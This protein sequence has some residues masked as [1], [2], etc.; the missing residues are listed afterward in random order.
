MD[1]TFC[2]VALRQRRNSPSAAVTKAALPPTTP[3]ITAPKSEKNSRPVFPN[4]GF[5]EHSLCS[6]D[7]SG[8]NKRFEI[9]LKM[10]NTHC[11]MMGIFLLQLAVLEQSPCAT[12]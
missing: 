5:T 7:K 1:P 6:C 8:T 10:T 3:A 2:K 9:S 11:N 4:L 12:N